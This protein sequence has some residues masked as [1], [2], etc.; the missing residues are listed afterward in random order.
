MKESRRWWPVVL[1]ACAT[2]PVRQAAPPDAEPVHVRAP[3]QA[4]SPAPALPTASA[5]LGARA[6]HHDD[7]ARAVLYTWTTPRQIAALRASRELLVAESGAGLGPSLFVGGLM[8]AAQG[9]STLARTLLDDPR[10]R[11]RRY[12]W[13][14]PF[15]TTMGLGPVRYGDA[16]V[17]V[18]LADTAVV[19]RFRPGDAEPFAAAT[20]DGAA[21]AIAGLDP[22]RIAAVYHVRDGAEDAVAFREYVVVNEAQI[23]RWS[24][25]TPEVRAQV[26]ADLELVAGLVDELAWLPAEAIAAPAKAMWPRALPGAAPLDRWHASLAFDNPRY[27]PSRSNLLAIVAALKNY[28]PAGEAFEHRP[29]DQ[30]AQASHTAR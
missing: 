3:A 27:Q 29:G 28:D 16:L 1:V 21:V 5:R 8:R 15:A 7:Y 24:V 4:P 26:E 12:A 23:A 22:S 2:A 10:L 19:V 30:G 14:S 11:R 20:L 13:T 9:G 17:R 18:E 25:A 6:V